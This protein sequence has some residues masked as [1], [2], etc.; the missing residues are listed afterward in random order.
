MRVFLVRHGEAEWAPDDFLREL[1]PE[2]RADV[3][4]LADR[5]AAAGVRPEEIRHSPLV[6]AVQTAEIL[7]ARLRPGHGLLE[8]SGAG[9]GGDPEIAALELALADAPVLVVTHMP[10]VA[11]L[12]G[13]LVSGR[14]GVAA[15][16]FDTAELRGFERTGD[17]WRRSL[18]L[19]GA[20]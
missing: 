5:A 20:D 10:F 9:P 7:A 11:L 19:L 16:P 18:R 15:T 14:R 3:V 6:R 4:R 1:T 8:V 2:G 17:V 13:R 12:E